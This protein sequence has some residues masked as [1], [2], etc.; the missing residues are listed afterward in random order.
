MANK[1]VV[2]MDEKKQEKKQKQKVDFNGNISKIR[3]DKK[4]DIPEIVFT[5]RRPT[6]KADVVYKGEAKPLD[7]FLKALQDLSEV[8]CEI[9]EM[10]EKVD[11]TL[12]TTVNFS[13][14]GGIIISGQ[15]ELGNGVPQPLC[16]N[17]PHILIENAK[18]GY[19]LPDYAKEQIEELKRQAILYANGESA[20]K[21]QSLPLVGTDN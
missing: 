10:E 17:T 19:E 1:K 3:I 14:K 5:E 9:C 7:S 13:P 11:D 4:T 21:Q 15:I 6:G 16:L 20:E 8:F 12:I 18:G 2:N